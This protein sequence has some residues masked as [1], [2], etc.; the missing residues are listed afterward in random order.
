L[1]CGSKE[2]LAKDPSPQLRLTIGLLKFD[3]VWKIAHEHHS[4]PAGT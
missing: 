3:G 1:R 4:F 2:E